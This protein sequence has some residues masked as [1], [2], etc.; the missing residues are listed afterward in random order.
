MKTFYITFWQEHT[1]RI[2]WNTLDKDCVWMIYAEDYWK[3]REIAFELTWWKFCFMY[4]DLE[5]VWME[6]Y[7][8]WLIPIN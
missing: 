7:H 1:H 5:K 3:A 2:N 8:R 6:Y 4:E